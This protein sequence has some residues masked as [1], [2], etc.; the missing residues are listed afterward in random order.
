M[1]RINKNVNVN[2][3]KMHT[4]NVCLFQQEL[5]WECKRLFGGLISSLNHKPGEPTNLHG[6]RTTVSI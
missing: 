2:T 1:N 4:N 5:F 3:G 6:M